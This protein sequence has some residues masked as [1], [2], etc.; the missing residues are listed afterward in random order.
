MST[1]AALNP[2]RD[3]RRYVIEA[4]AAHIA[5]SVGLFEA[6]VT[7]RTLAELSNE[8]GWS[9]SALRPLVRALVACGHLRESEPDTFAL[10]ERSQSLFLPSSNAYIG[11][12]LSFMRT[13][14]AY[15]SYP[16]ILRG[17][18]AVGLNESQWSYVTRG[19]AMYATAG[20]QTLLARFPELWSRKPLRILDVGCGQGVYLLQLARALPH[21]TLLGI[22]PTRRVVE[23]ARARLASLMPSPPEVRE[24]HLEDV[25]GMF[26]VVLINQ[27]FHVTGVDVAAQLLRQARMR[28]AP[29]GYVFVQEILD[30]SDDPSPA[31]FGLNMRLLFDQGCVLTLNEQVDLMKHAGFTRVDIHPIDG[32]TPGLAYVSGQ[33]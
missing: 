27:I 11:H 10:S 3:Y 33:L 18:A 22:D 4:W 12:A 7:P 30:G 1:D 26:D 31:L 8:H 28:L 24:A 29:G 25:E 15:L 32:S 23:D 6:L 13:T 16:E 9:P 20:I 17:G 21:A 5:V 2:L 19:S 14:Q